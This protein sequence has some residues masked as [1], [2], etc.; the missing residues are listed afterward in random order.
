MICRQFWIPPW[1]SGWPWNQSKNS[2][3]SKFRTQTHSPSWNERTDRI[4]N[5]EIYGNIFSLFSINFFVQNSDW[6]SIL[7]TT[8]TRFIKIGKISHYVTEVIWLFSSRIP[9]GEVLWSKFWLENQIV[10]EMGDFL[11]NIDFQKYSTF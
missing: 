1:S 8:L 9:T 4:P 3:G 5:V 11:N 2:T 6:T 10:L 7:H